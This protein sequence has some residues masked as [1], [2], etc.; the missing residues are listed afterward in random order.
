MNI[1]Q[2][3]LWTHESV[4]EDWAVLAMNDDDAAY[5]FLD[6]LRDQEIDFQQLTKFRITELPMLTIKKPT[7]E[8]QT[9]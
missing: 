3:E 9:V 4:K 8:P 6:W 2:V 5:I 7:S 1:Y